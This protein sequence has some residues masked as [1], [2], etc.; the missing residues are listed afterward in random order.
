M[1]FTALHVH[2]EYSLLDGAAKI[3]DLVARAEELGMDSLA[4]TD[5]GNLFGVIE[6]YLACKERGINPVIGC[7]VYVSPGSRFDREPKERS[8]DVSDS[9]YFHLI[10]LAEN[11]T[12]YENLMK[13]VSRGYTE[14]FYYKPRVD[15]ELL[16]KYHEGLICLS[17]CLAGEVARYLG[18]DHY[19]DAKAAAL[20]YLKIFGEGNYFLELQDHGIPLQKQVNAGLLR[21]SKETGIPLVATNDSHYVR[22]ED[23]QFHDILLCVQTGKKLNDQD[24]LRYEKGQ[25]CLKS[26]AEMR[27]LFPYA[28]DAVERTH[29]IAERCHVEFEFGKLKLPK[30]HPLPEGMTAYE[31]L[32]ELCV[33]GFTK[34]YYEDEN[35]KERSEAVLTEYMERLKYELDTIRNMGYVD[36]FL[37]VWDYIRYAKDHGILVGPGRGS[38]AGSMAAYCLEITNIDPM[39][40]LLLF[41]RF[42]NPE[43]VSMPDIDVDFA[44]ERRGEV[45]DYVTE[46]YGAD[47]VAQIIT[48]G[49]FAARAAI[50]DVGRVMDLPYSFCDRVAKLVP[51]ELKMTLAKALT[52]S[53]EL[54]ELYRNDP[55]VRE[56]I[57]YSKQIEGL[58]RHTSVH[59][60]GVVISGR[61]VDDYVPLSKNAEGIVTTQF[62]M[63]RLEELGLLKMDFLALRNLTIIDQATKMAM[64]DSGDVIDIEDLSMDDPRVFATIGSGYCEGIFQLESTGMRNFMKILKPVNL[65]DVIAGISLYRPG[66]MDFIPRYLEGRADPKRI[67]FECPEM[68][69]ILAPTFGCIVYQEQVMQIVRDLA[70]YSMGRSDLVRRAMSKK[71]TSVMEQERKNFV[72]GN[73]EEGIPGCIAKG[74]SEEVANKIYDEMIDFAKYA[75]NKSHAAC[76]A[77]L[78]Y[79]TAYLKCYYPVE[80]MAALMT[81]VIDQTSKITGYIEECRRMGIR[82]LPPDINHSS[83]LFTVERTEEDKLAIRYGLSA[84]KNVGTASVDRI[85]EEREKHGPF[86]SL[87]DFARRVDSR[88]INKRMVENMIKAGAF[89]SIPGNR[90]QKMIAFNGIFDSVWKA[91]AT[92]VEGQMTLFDFLNFSGV[93]TEGV[94][95]R[96]ETGSSDSYGDNLPKVE[97]YNRMDLLEFE[98]EVLG[99]YVSGHPLEEYLDL[100]VASVTAHS[101]DFLPQ[102]E[103]YDA[104]EEGGKVIR[105]RQSVVIGGILRSKTVKNTKNGAAMA[106]ITME[107]LYGSVEVILFPREFDRYNSL[108]VA[109][110][111][112]L[113][114]GTA[115]MDDEETGKV[116]ASE[117]ILFENAPREL[118]IRFPDLET[119]HEK[120]QAV[121]DLLTG[122]GP[123]QPVIYL[124][125]ERSFRRLPAANFVKVTEEL[126]ESIRKIVG[127]DQTAVRYIPWKK[128]KKV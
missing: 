38:A 22:E 117:M 28:P 4:I 125:K 13:L 76:Y 61:P 56:L 114:A 54:K 105:D 127:D 26:E 100:M 74:I 120:E 48:F 87:S 104:E 21:L 14:G 37:I 6:F 70:G 39:K 34:R 46:K 78:A 79:Q 53:S 55:Q 29:E 41:E 128:S 112:L 90:K 66:P 1:A 77:V 40:Y 57:D 31:Y 88:E 82:I 96:Q 8:E 119:Y 84:I 47:C 3:G 67:R 36:Y 19:E 51:T 68:E 121:S 99:H 33:N 106:F 50:R 25:F 69:P 11:Q 80:F 89:D 93:A 71:K 18:S 32:E 118:W 86:T 102:E 17:A 109:G 103:E 97:E 5:H 12:G 111:R 63:G 91:K 15:M 65:E 52:E 113:I 10:L 49:T 59:A 83:A 23:W 116:L 75:F 58:P 107:D 64:I 126:L 45:I 85:K 7:E 16:E 42:L 122:D 115:S 62:T 94:E 24:R 2:T 123:D 30:Y 110:N 81:S 35:G 92:E 72:Y 108:L 101:S 98:Q 20:R 95:V 44:Y 60:A 9:K 124:K 73:K 27:A 43:R